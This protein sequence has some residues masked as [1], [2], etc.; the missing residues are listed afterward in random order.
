MTT[1][2][3]FH[4]SKLPSVA[5]ICNRLNGKKNGDRWLTARPNKYNR[6]EAYI[7]YWYY[8]D[9]E[10]AIKGAGDDDTTEIVGVLKQNGKDRILKRVY[11]YI[12]LLTNTLEVYTGDYKAEEIAKVIGDLLGAD[13]TPIKLKSEDLQKIYSQHSVELKQ[14]M[15]KNIHGLMYEI[16]RGR[17]LDNNEKFKQYLQSFPDC[18]RVISFRPKIRFLNGNQK[19]QVTINGDRGT[20]RLSSN[21]IFKYR[22]RFE[23]RQ[24]TF[25]VA[26]TLGLLG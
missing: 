7:A 8:E 12:Y 11:C 19:Y 25:L 15:F 2:T 16:L 21:G 1:L 10:E 13:V 17:L 5:E 20:I 4:C 24:L 23:I 14:A 9:I 3:V 6:N 18:L 26:A 22:S